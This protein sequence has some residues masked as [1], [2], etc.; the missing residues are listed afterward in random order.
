MSRVLIF[1]LFIPGSLLAQANRYFVTFKDKANTSYSVSNPSQFL[2][3]KSIDRRTRE[4]FV[5]STEDFPVNPNYVKQVKATGAQVYFTSRWFNGLLIQ[6]TPSIAN[7]VVASLPFVQ[8]VEL[9]AAGTRL[10]GGR[11]KANQKLE[12]TNAE[13]LP[14]N[15]HQNAMI[16]LDKMHAA[17]FYGEGV[18][19]AIF[20]SG[21]NGTDTLSAFKPIY[22]DGRVKSVFNFVQN[23]A[24]VYAGYPHG[25]WVWSIMAASIPTRYQGGVPNANYFLFQTEDALSE[26]RVEEY[27][28]LFAAEKA[29]SLGIDVV[30]SSLGYSEFDDPTMDYSYGSMDGKTT[31]VARAARKL[32]DRGV[33]VVN[34]AGNEGA[35]SWRYIISPA[36]VNGIIACGGVNAFGERV[37]FSSIGPSFDR[38]IK[39]DVSAMAWNCAVVNEDGGLFTGSGTSFASP[40]VACLAVGLRQAFP[41]ATAREIYSLITSSASQAANPDDLLGYGIPDF[42]KAKELNGQFQVY[43][44]PVKSDTGINIDFDYPDGQ[45]VNVLLFNSNGQKIFES[46][47]T[48]LE[49]RNPYIIDAS[50]MAIGMYYLRIQTDTSVR[51][52][53][54]LKVN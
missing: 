4:H 5:T 29:D 28:W 18:D 51:S 35:G 22:K 31:V 20:D 25:T 21:F 27:N 2:S 30:N 32:I 49:N 23:S 3:Q 45:T 44:N 19:V 53:R 50:S 40:L 8:S 41:L 47:T 26:N 33:V 52:V 34:A 6:T 24:N 54:I 12:R 7:S 1:L 48:M 42:S 36:D 16:G 17:G 9:V 46:A 39:P 10:S 43:P 11:V 13:S 38:R 37:A 14:L 15:E